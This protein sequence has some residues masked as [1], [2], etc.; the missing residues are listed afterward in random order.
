MIRLGDAALPALRSQVR[1]GSLT[2]RRYA[3]AVLGY[4]GSPVD[5]ELLQR[6]VQEAGQGQLTDVADRSI[7]LINSFSRPEDGFTEFAVI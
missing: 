3:A 7:D 2:S 4:T 6:V 5:I 1:D